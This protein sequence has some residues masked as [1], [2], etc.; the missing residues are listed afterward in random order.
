MLGFMPVD[1]SKPILPCWQSLAQELHNDEYHR[2][3]EERPDDT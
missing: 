1:Y 3:Q 2:D